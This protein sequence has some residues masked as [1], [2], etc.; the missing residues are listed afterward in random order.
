MMSDWV[1]QPSPNLASSRLSLHRTGTSLWES[2]REIL[3]R[4]F[5]S[6]QA[7]TSVS[8]SRYLDPGDMCSPVDSPCRALSTSTVSC[9]ALC[10]DAVIDVTFKSA[11]ISGKQPVRSL[12]SFKPWDSSGQTHSSPESLPQQMGIIHTRAW[13]SSPSVA[14]LDAEESVSPVFEMPSPKDVSK[15]QSETVTPLSEDSPTD[16]TPS[17]L[18]GR[19]QERDLKYALQTDPVFRTRQISTPSHPHNALSLIAFTPSSGS[20][21]S[22]GPVTPLSSAFRSTDKRSPYVWPDLSLLLPWKPNIS[23][24]SSLDR[25]NIVRAETSESSPQPPKVSPQ[26]NPASVNS[27]SLSVSSFPPRHTSTP[28]HAT[29]LK[30]AKTKPVPP[31]RTNSRTKPPP[32]VR[33]AS[34]L[35]S[36]TS[37]LS[38]SFVLPTINDPPTEQVSQSEV[39]RQQFTYTPFTPAGSL[40]SQSNLKRVSKG[41]TGPKK[42][43]TPD[44]S[45]RTPCSWRSGKASDDRSASF[46][47][48]W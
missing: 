32:P 37:M 21:S 13:S 15:Y 39:K 44:Q 4:S 28:G 19:V 17:P 30:V 26:N 11:S 31:P 38:S 22:S 3:R 43:E 2:R 34:S 33:G 46:K 1:F 35:K 10:N 5:Q 27:R 36:S 6:P 20:S 29:T 40:L 41:S 14:V 45:F 47:S 9:N 42:H 23:T 24:S 12:L 16:K 7:N 18:R 8:H 48:C 25:L